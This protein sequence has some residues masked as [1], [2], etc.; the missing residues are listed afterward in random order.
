M[1]PAAM[2]YGEA[3]ALHAA[4]GQVLTEAYRTHP[5]RFINGAPKPPCLPGA[6]WIN[7][8]AREIAR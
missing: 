5:N 4:R 6:V 3:H 7:S 2:H 1:T 8:P